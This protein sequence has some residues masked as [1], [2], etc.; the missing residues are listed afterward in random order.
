FAAHPQPLVYS[1]LLAAGYALFRMR[2]AVGWRIE[3]GGWRMEDCSANYLLSSILHFQS[4]AIRIRLRFLIQCTA[5]F[6][7]GAA[8]AAVQL[9]PAWRITRQSVRQ[10]VPY[11]FFTWHSL[12]PLT[13]L[14]TLFPFFHGQ[15]KTIYQLPYWGNYWHHNEA[16]IY[17]GAMALSLAAAGAVYAWQTRWRAGMFWS[18]AAVVG[19]VL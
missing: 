12:H 15:G 18:L 8:L 13:L 9:I 11:E 6:V 7:L 3:D 1:S 17:L 2:N 4:P 16:Q 14:T 19:V 5:M 10:Q